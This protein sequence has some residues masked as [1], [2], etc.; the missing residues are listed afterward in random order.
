MQTLMQRP[1]G[2]PTVDA[3]AHAAAIGGGD[4]WRRRDVRASRSEKKR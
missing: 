2:A 4:G 3:G 1:H